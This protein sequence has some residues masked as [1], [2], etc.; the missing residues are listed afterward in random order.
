MA[1]RTGYSLPCVCSTA[2]GAFAIAIGLCGWLIK[3][4][5]VGYLAPGC[6]A[7]TEAH[8][9]CQVAPA[10]WVLGEGGYDIVPPSAPVSS[11]TPLR[12]LSWLLTR[13]SVGSL[14]ARHLLVRDWRLCGQR[15][16]R[17]ALAHAG[18]VSPCLKSRQTSNNV[19]KLRE[20]AGQVDPAQYPSLFQPVRRL[21]AEEHKLHAVAAAQP[22][23]NLSNILRNPTALPRAQRLDK[24]EEPLY[25][26][27]IDY[28]HAY[29]SEAL[30]PSQAMQRFLEGV[31]STRHLGIWNAVHEEDIMRQA[32]AS[33]RRW[34]DK[35]PISVLD[36]VPVAVKDMISVKG[37]VKTFGTRWP[38]ETN[39]QQEDDIV[40]ARFR[41]KGAIIVGT[42]AMTEFGVSPLGFN[43]HYNGT[44]NPYD[45]R[46][47]SGG[48]SAGSA[49]AVAAGL[50]PLAVGFDGGGSIRIPSAICGIY[51]LM[52]GFARVPFSPAEAGS[53]FVVHAGPM[54]ATVRDLA[55]G[56][57]V[58]TPNEPGHVLTTLYGQASGG[59][60]QPHLAR[61]SDISDLS[62]IRIG[63]FR[64]HFNDAPAAHVAAANAAVD[65]LVARG[66]TV[67]NIEIP[68]MSALQFAHAFTISQQFAF[69]Q[70]W[71]F[72]NDKLQELELEPATRIQ[73]TLGRVMTAVEIAAAHRLKAWAFQYVTDLYR[74][75][76]DVIISPT[77][78][79]ATPIVTPDIIPNGLS[80]T[81]TIVSMIKYM[82]LGNLLGLPGVSV[83]VGYGPGKPE[84]D[85][86]PQASGGKLPLGALLMAD[87][88]QEA[89]LLRLAHALENDF[90][91]ELRRRPEIFFDVDLRRPTMK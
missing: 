78:G 36:G 45:A 4:V 88:W 84:V 33:D 25:W 66:A 85:R 23:S 2:L 82:F 10:A 41:A 22:A 38:E 42:T 30:T 87:H 68:H 26:E 70:D 16:Q 1:A 61:F 9:Y 53:T 11:G 24:D 17:R 55:I 43:S 27:V 50:V 74:N 7:S 59:P 32:R 54:A 64:D 52:E 35:Q 40:V 28:Y 69:G 3:D 14:V 90:A 12:F 71:R 19:H 80:D 76:V 46:F 67:V 51:G 91:G 15:P 44:Y 39:P 72:H 37:Y 18:A 6:D 8:S 20:L 73:L 79:E 56:H 65:A 77:A 58:M 86:D 13:T 75:D 49:A 81:S 83:P 57:A 21:S 62:D 63:I 47:M 89:T 48:S 5:G 34:R 31:A 29:E 60:P